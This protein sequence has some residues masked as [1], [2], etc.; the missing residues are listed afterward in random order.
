VKK[1]VGE[2]DSQNEIRMRVKVSKIQNET[3]ERVTERE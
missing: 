3:V 2:S 1:R